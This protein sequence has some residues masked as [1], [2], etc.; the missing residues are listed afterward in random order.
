M[1]LKRGLCALQKHAS[2]QITR[3]LA[4]PLATSKRRHASNLTAFYTGE[5]S[6]NIQLETN[7][8]SFHAQFCFNVI[9]SRLTGAVTLI[10][11]DCKFLRSFDLL[12]FTVQPKPRFREIFPRLILGLRW[13]RP[14]FHH[15]HFMIFRF[16]VET[17]IIYL[18]ASLFFTTSSILLRIFTK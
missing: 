4:S 3:S 14:D 15:R 16:R 5:I 6:V 12:C 18:V 9:R 2:H 17:T 8:C 7:Y 1:S 10:L 11:T 13:W